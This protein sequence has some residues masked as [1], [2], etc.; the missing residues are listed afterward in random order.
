MANPR[1]GKFFFIYCLFVF[2]FPHRS[3]V[4]V[5][6]SSSFEQNQSE[7]EVPFEI[8]QY[9]LLKN[10]EELVRNLSDVVSKLE[11]R[12]SDIPTAVKREQLNTMLPD[13]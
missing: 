11:L 5:Y 1:K 6:S 2:V 10:I 8:R 7:T 13:R 12:L 4:F 3:K 9:D